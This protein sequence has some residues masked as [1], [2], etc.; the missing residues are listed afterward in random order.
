MMAKA[1]DELFNIARTEQDAALRNEAIR[2]LGMLHQS[3]KLAQL[4]QAGIAKKNSPRV[5]VPAG[6][7]PP[8]SSK[9]SAPK[10]IPNC[11]ARRSV[12][13]A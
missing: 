11:V 6:T 12:R 8:A 7:I 3:D 4:Y 5:D 2:S 1:S 9:S 10:R 13:W